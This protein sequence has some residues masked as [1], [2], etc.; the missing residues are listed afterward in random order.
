MKTTCHI[1]LNVRQK[2]IA[3]FWFF[4]VLPGLSQVNQ[5][6]EDPHKQSLNALNALRHNRKMDSRGWRG[7]IQAGCLLV[8]IW[9]P[10]VDT[11]WLPG[12]LWARQWCKMSTL[13]W[14]QSWHSPLHPQQSYFGLRYC[15]GKD[16]WQSRSHSVSLNVLTVIFKI[17]RKQLTWQFPYR[18]NVTGGWW[19]SLLQQT[20]HRS[21]RTCFLCQC[22]QKSW[23]L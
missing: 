5:I 9:R 22:I 13:W 15:K 18:Y 1:D 4:E 21:W 10:P 11:G 14:N 12:A 23:Q 8:L 3:V 19:R 2:K 6:T 17:S 16:D 7:Y 20:W